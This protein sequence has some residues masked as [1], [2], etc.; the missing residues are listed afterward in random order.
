M[1]PLTTR[2]SVITCLSIVL[3]TAFALALLNRYGL[4]SRIMG[5]VGAPQDR[6]V[7]KSLVDDPGQAYWLWKEKGFQGRVVLF[8]ADR[9]ESF[10]PDELLP[11]QMFRAYPLQLYRIA[12]EMEDQQL[13]GVTFLYVASLNKIA[14]RIVAVVPPAEVER[15][16]GLVPKVKNSRSS[17]QGV[18]LSRQGF[19]RWFTTG[20]RLTPVGEP[21]LL[22]VG[23][24][25]FSHAEPEAFLAQLGAAGVRTDCVILCRERGK[26]GITAANEE[27][28]DRFA[29]LLGAA[30]PPGGAA[31]GAAP[32]PRPQQ[33]GPGL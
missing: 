5:Q 28:L 12:K 9:W 18:F 10:D 21:V 25:Y 17:D 15:M 1:Q 4:N 11:S 16:R 14:R 6:Q 33:G 31:A 22:Y 24:S 29:K 23:A 13:N 26:P 27:K 20:A 30:V 19:P 32:A 8:A 3:L 2:R 7:L